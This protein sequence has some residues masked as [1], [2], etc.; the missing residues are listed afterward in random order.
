MTSLRDPPRLRDPTDGELLRALPTA[1]LTTVPLAQRI[2]PT[3]V[4]AILAAA[5][6]IVSPSSLDLAAHLFRARLFEIEG[7]G[8][9]DNLWYSGH[10]ILGYSVLFPPVSA[11]ISP[12]LA[13][14]IAATA[15]AA[16]FEPL[17]RRHYGPDAWLGAVLF[18][19]ATAVNLY[20]GR[21]AF[22][23]GALPAMATV[24][25]LDR[26]RTTL[27]CA[28]AVLT[29]LCSP[30]AAL[31][32]AVAAAA[33]AIGAYAAARRIRPA[34]GAV[35]VTL[36]AL[37]P[38]AAL[39][40]AFPEG[41]SE[42]FAFGSLWP[43]P[44][45]AIG[46][47]WALPRD[48]WKLRAA[49]VLYTLGTIAAYLMPTPMGS[50]A[51]RLGTFIAAPLAALLWWRRRSALLLLFALPLLYLEWQAP[52]HDLWAA[53]GNASSSPAYYQPLLNFLGRES[54]PPAAPFRTE[55]PFTRFHWEAYVVASR[56][57]IARGWERQLDIK[58][59]PIF[60][61][62]HLTAARYQAWLHQN[63]IRFV[64][65]SDAPLDF[66]SRAE[67]ALISRGLPYLRLVM[68][69]AHWRVY[70]VVNAT[71]IVQGAATLR[72]MSP[73][74]FT[75]R[76]SRPGTVLVHVRFTPYW[77]LAQGSGCVFPAGDFTGLTLRRPGTVKL[78]THFA[79]SRI[80]AR[81]PR[82]R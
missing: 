48:A 36:A 78:Q 32:A 68:H 58:D 74:S 22:A 4:A 65:A 7:F 50:N 63:A 5:Y 56:F 34:L 10:H 35:A 15:T 72:A 49:V 27:A 25:A 80:G 40:I 79:L 6:V 9:W 46:A 53:S 31:F 77:A 8:V 38:I 3:L 73:D 59:N 82:C 21:L 67:M 44:L 24:V 19:A 26:R 20:T 64:A 13:A 2:A 12:Q 33:Y 61:S 60:Y 23:Y 54:A 42:P 70:A 45:L 16:L 11:A 29:A 76:A 30:V 37:V 81:S 17:A 28:L 43:I 66:S 75:L 71:P 62:G 14:A 1:E 18:G 52:I 47:L 55:I 57:A 39:G 41:G 69:S 51:T